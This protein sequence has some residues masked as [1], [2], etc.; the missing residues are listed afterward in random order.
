M[1][2][3]PLCQHPV[4]APSLQEII[5]AHAIKGH[6]LAV[7]ET[8]WSGRGLPVNTSAIFDVMYADDPNGGPAQAKMYRAFNRALAGLR[9]KLGK[10]SIAIEPAGYRRG[11]RLSLG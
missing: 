11:Y 3:C 5:G 8:V 10:S 4:A 2:N 7:L 6:E 9:K 1:S